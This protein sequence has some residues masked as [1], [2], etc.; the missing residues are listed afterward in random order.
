MHDSLAVR[1]LQRRSNLH[2]QLEQRLR[3]EWAARDPLLQRL[4]LKQLHSDEVLTAS[5][6]NF[7]KRTDAGMVQS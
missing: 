4:P 2:C 7:V 5:L 6:I 1:R 3:I